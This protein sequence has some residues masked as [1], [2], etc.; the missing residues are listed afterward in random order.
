MRLF[1]AGISYRTAPL[2]LRERLAVPAAQQVMATARLMAAGNLAE[3]VLLSTCNRVELY[4]VGDSVPR[5]VVELFGLLTGDPC[6]AGEQLFRRQGPEAL[7]HLFAVASGLDSMALGE[8][9]ITGQVKV[10]YER[11]Q[12]A[13]LT[14]RVLNQAFQKSLAT[15]KEIRTRTSVGR[16]ATSIGSAAVQ[17]AERVFG[18]TLADKTILIIGTGQMGEVCVRHLAKRGVRELWI[19]NRTLERAQTLATECGGRPIPW[20]EVSHLMAQTDVVIAAT[21]CPTW[22]FGRAEVERL[23][24]SRHHRPL[25]LVDLGVPRNIEPEVNRLENVYLHNI[26]DL[27]VI[28]RHNRLH[29]QNE[30]AAGQEIIA[31]AVTALW[32]RLARRP[33]SPDNAT[34]RPSSWL[35]PD[36]SVAVTG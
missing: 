12:S 5:D 23:M 20:T 9:E 7:A 15:A 6:D 24:Q 28:V 14:G 36:T 10:A 19:S 17:L 27:E 22:L 25:V 29:R 34:A 11:A 18:R 21:G 30:L 35:L 1:V 16:G 4:A 31:G 13:G 32:P 8:T 3:A 33:E 26:D 2:A